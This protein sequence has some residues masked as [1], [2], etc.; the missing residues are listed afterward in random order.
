MLLG[1]WRLL[2]SEAPRASPGPLCPPSE[3]VPGQ[4]GKVLSCQETVQVLSLFLSLQLL[5][6][7]DLCLLNWLS[8][9]GQ[10]FFQD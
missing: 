5:P 9:E 3:T 6:P 10:G 4:V 8:M 7:P 2:F 1:P